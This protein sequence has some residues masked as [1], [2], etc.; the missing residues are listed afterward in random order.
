ME[1]E[2]RVWQSHSDTVTQPGEHFEIIASSTNAPVA[3]GAHKNKPFFGV[4]FHPETTQTEN[5]QQ[6]I[7]NFV[8][9]ICGGDTLCTIE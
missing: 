1:H 2:Q 9:D 4:Q 8:V 3:A 6:N 5:G 7:E